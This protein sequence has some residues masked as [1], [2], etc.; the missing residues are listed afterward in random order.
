M[1]RSE[2]NTWLKNPAKPPEIDPRTVRL[3]A[4]RVNRYATPDTVARLWTD[5]IMMVHLYPCTVHFDI[6]VYVHQLMDLFISTSE[7]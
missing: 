7:H 5:L 3:V 1:V 4:Q 2:G 6:N